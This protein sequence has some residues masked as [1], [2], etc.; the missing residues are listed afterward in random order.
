MTRNRRFGFP[1]AILAE[2]SGRRI[3][4][5]GE[6]LKIFRGTRAGEGAKIF[7]EV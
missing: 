4:R 6:I 7:A 3:T 5:S 2:E 1:I